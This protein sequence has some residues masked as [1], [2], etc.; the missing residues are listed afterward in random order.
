MTEQ[1]SHPGVAHPGVDTDEEYKRI[2]IQPQYYNCVCIIRAKR[3][4][5]TSKVLSVNGTQ[6]NFYAIINRLDYTYSDKR[7][8]HV[9]KEIMMKKKQKSKTLTE[10]TWFKKKIIY[11]RGILYSNKPKS[12]GETY[13]IAC[14]IYHDNQDLLLASSV[15]RRHDSRYEGQTT[16]HHQRN[17]RQLRPAYRVNP[18]RQPTYEERRNSGS[19]IQRNGQQ[20]PNL[21]KTHQE[22]R[23][24]DKIHLKGRETYHPKTLTTNKYNVSTKP[25]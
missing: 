3:T 8:L 10:N 4:G 18:L 11:T 1:R 14:T 16:F 24:T 5:A 22:I 17:D 9:L 13:V 12:L 23:L 7:P 20:Q 21:Y 19:Y 2:Y 25:N 6:L 15:P